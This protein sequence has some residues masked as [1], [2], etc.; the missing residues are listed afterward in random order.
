MTIQTNINA[1][2]PTKPVNSTSTQRPS[3]ASVRAN[4]SA[5]KLALQGLLDASGGSYIQHYRGKFTSISALTTSIPAAF[6]GDYAQVDAGAADTVVNY[7]WDDEAGWVIGSAGSGATTTDE[8]IEG[9]VNLY[10][11]DD[12]ARAAVQQV[13]DAAIPNYHYEP[14]VQ[15]GFNNSVYYDG[16]QNKVPNFYTT[17]D[18]DVYV[19]K[20]RN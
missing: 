12:R 9:S 3:L 5:I 7:N 16:A 13:I 2:D 10:F 17:P 15:L 11:T 1:V 8:L 18:G 19:M 20:V 4:F 14:M 6:A